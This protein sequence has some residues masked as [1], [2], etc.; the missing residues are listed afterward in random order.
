MPAYSEFMKK[1]LVTWTFNDETAE[2]DLVK[3]SGLGKIP[4]LVH[5]RSFT[6]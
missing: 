4:G 1:E 5:Q 2:H 3:T 6:I